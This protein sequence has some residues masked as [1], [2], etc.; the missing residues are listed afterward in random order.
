MGSASRAS[1]S[2]AGQTLPRHSLFPCLVRA[3]SC[4]PGAVSAGNFG[5]Q[6]G[7]MG[8]VGVGELQ[9]FTAQ[10]GFSATG[11][12]RAG[13]PTGS[14]A[15][16]K[17][18]PPSPTKPH[19]LTCKTTKYTSPWE[20]SPDRGAWPAHPGSTR[21]Q[22]SQE[23]GSAHSGPQFPPLHAAWPGVWNCSALCP[24]PS[25]HGRS[26]CPLSTWPARPALPRSCTLKRSI[27]RG[28]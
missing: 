24:V 15:V 14:W 26:P 12:H 21:A 16:S 3:Q 23:A 7:L 17:R 1:S 10:Q 4:L 9:L 20:S 11:H 2:Q 22:H 6:V 18:R 5:F 27:R 28:P 13:N 8:E 19:S 25:C